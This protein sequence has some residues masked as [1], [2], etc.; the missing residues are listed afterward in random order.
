MR[1][2]P[3][4]SGWHSGMRSAA[5]LAAWIP[6]TRATESTSPLLTAPRATSEV[7]SGCMCTRARATARRWLGSLGV[8]STIRA[9]P[10][11]S[12]W[13]RP[14]S[15]M[16]RIL[17]GHRAAARRSAAD[18]A[19]G[20]PGPHE[21]HL[22]D[23][24]PGPLR[25][26]ARLDGVGQGVVACVGAQDRAEIVVLQREQAIPELPVG[27]EADPVAL[28]A[29]RAGDAGDHPDLSPPVGVAEPLRRLV[30]SDD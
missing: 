8:T 13:V 1:T 6:A 4:R 27:G 9:R 17:Q 12:R 11:G 16:A 2:D 25:P 29:E 15:D 30:P 26:H 20:P 14:R 7:V 24:V 21:L 23:G 19:H 18:L 5:R 28:L 22:V 3:T 10:S